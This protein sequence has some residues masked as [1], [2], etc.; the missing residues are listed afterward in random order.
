MVSRGAYLGSEDEFGDTP[1]HWAVREGHSNVVAAIL[2]SQISS[3]SSPL[4]S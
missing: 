3:F 4:P 2:E 1:L